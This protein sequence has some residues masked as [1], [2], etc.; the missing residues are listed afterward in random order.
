M[1]TKISFRKIRLLLPYLILAA[2]VSAGACKSLLP[3]SITPTVTRDSYSSTIQEDTGYP[4]QDEGL[5][6]APIVV[7]F[8]PQGGEELPVS[9]EIVLNFD[10][11]M[12]HQKTGEAWQLTGPDQIEIKGEFTWPDSRTMRFKPDTTLRTGTSYTGILRREAVS[13]RGIQ[14]E[15]PVLLNFTTTTPLEVSQVFP[16]DGSKDVAVDAVITAIFNRPVAPLVVE[17]DKEQLPDPMEINPPVP[18]RGEWVSTSVY[19]FQ[20]GKPLKGGMDYIVTVRAGL[21]DAAGETVLEEDV[22]WKFTT[23]KPSIQSFELSGGAVNPEPGLEGVLLDEYFTVNFNQPMDVGSSEESIKLL[24]EGGEPVSLITSWND[25]D[26]RVII[27]PTLDLQLGTSYSL[28]VDSTAKASDGGTLARGLNWNFR[29]I[30][31]PAVLTISPPEGQATSGFTPELWIKFASPMDFESVKEN[32]EVQPQ[33]KED[34]QW[35]YDPYDWSI[36]A[37]ILQPSTS[38]QVRALPGM[39]DIYGNSISTEKIVNFTT[40]QNWPMAGLQ[41]PWEPALLREGGPQEFYVTYR[42]VN[43]IGVK[44]YKIT[45]QEFI[46]LQTGTFNRSEFKPQEKDLVWEYELSNSGRI[47]ET[48]LESLTPV[49]TTGDALDPGFYFLVL[50]TPDISYPQQSSL[51]NRLMVVANADV[52]FKSSTDE[53]LL[54]VTDF[55]NG[56]PLENVSLTVYNRHFQP[57]GEGSTDE[58]GLLKLDLPGPEDPSDPRFVMTG[59]EDEFFAFTTSLWGSGVNLY[60]YGLWSSYYAPVNQVRVYAYTD[61]PIYR[62][63]QTVYYKGI[64]RRD[65]DLAYQLP[66]ANSAH[67]KVNNYKETVFEDD[68]PV[69]E[70]G[71]FSGEFTLDPDAVL[72]HY[73]IEVE[74]VDKKESVGGVGF[75]VAEYQRPEFQV[76][77]SVDAADL[78]NGEK[79]KAMVDADYY[80][81]GGVGNARVDW[82]LNASPFYFSPPEE[83]ANYSFEDTERDAGS[84]TDSQFQE[85]ETVAQGAGTTKPDGTFSVSLPADLSEGGFGRQLTFEATV[86]DISK[87]AVSGRA[88]VNAHRSMVYPG[89][90]PTSYVGTFGKENSF[91]LI[92]LDWDGKPVSGQNVA[93]EIVERRWYSVQ[94]Q[95]ASGRVE[96]KTNVEDIPIESLEATTD[97]L[98]QAKVSFVAPKGGVYRAT[99]SAEDTEGNDARSAAYLWVSGE[100][101]IPWRQTNDRSFDLVA[102]RSAYSPGDTAEILIASPFQGDST[103]LITVERGHILQQET[104]K[105]AS[106]SMVYKLPIAPEF[107]PNV[108]VSVLVVKGVDDTNPSP[109]FKMGVVELQVNTDQQKI[110]IEVS[111]EPQQA[112]PGDEVTYTIQA[113][114]E[115][116]EPLRAEFSLSLSD[117][118]TLSL[119]ESN[120]PPVLDFFYNERNLGVWTSAPLFLSLEDYNAEIQEMVAIGGGM[121]SGGGKGE[122]EL[123]VVSVRQDFPDTALWEAHIET[124][125]NGQAQVTVKLPDN[126]T[127]WRMDTRGVTLD[128]RVGQQNF[129]LISSK[130]LLVRPQTPRFLVEG[131]EAL[132]GTAVQNNTSQPLDV[133]VSLEYKG[134]SLADDSPVRIEIAAKS[135]ALVTWKAKADQGADRVDLVF[136]A[137]GGGFQDSSKP[138]QGTLEGHGIP[139]YRY[140]VRETA[141]TS[142]MLENGGTKIEAISLPAVNV[143]LQGSLHIEVSHS[144][145]AGLANGLNYL[146]DFPYGCIEQTISSFLPNVASTQAL[147]TAGI[148]NPQ[149][150]A[151]L[152]QQ[153]NQALQR[154]RNLQNPDGGWG[155]WP[156]D[157]QRSD[158]LTTAYVVLG[159]LE[160]RDRGYHVTED[161]LESAVNYL[162]TQVKFIRPVEKPEVLNR[163]AF[164]LDV[165][166]RAGKPNVSA[167]VRLY[168]QRQNAAIYARAFLLDAL[169]RIDPDDPRISTLLS[170]LNNQAISSAS[171][172]HWQESKPDPTNWNTDTRTTAIVLGIQSLIDSRNPLNA[173]AARWLMST[174][175]DGHWQGTQETAWTIMALTAWMEASGEAEPDYRYGVALNSEVLGGG[176]ADRQSLFET[177]ELIVQVTDMLKN[178]INRLAIARDDGSGN[179]YYTTFLNLYLPVE[180]AGALDQGIAISRSYI[181]FQHGDDL[182]QVGAVNEAMQGDLLLG[183]LTLVTPNDLHYIVVEDPLPAGLEAVDQTLQGSPQNLQPPA[184]YGL[185]EV[186]NQGWGWWYFD[187]T[188]LR[189]EKVVLSANY[190]PAGTYVYTYLVRAETAGVFNVIPPTAQEFYY[191]DVYGRGEG[192][193]FTV[194]P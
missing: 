19:A 71:T 87:N 155:W 92:L 102:D 36:R 26:T 80:S 86:S 108:F 143:D 119:V 88:V 184:D 57:I 44:L 7:D 95:D 135:Q 192:V 170:D 168:D 99:A 42:N 67:I 72:G 147:K 191:P 8:K 46:G 25:I 114:D 163:Q 58:D 62:P 94:E 20:P 138:P 70:F 175:T 158:S 128:T 73:S 151:D 140:Q 98:G 118:A 165:L 171:G 115:G 85:T 21:P 193:Q 28:V 123:G 183:R 51:D 122:D 48:V 129:D 1:K 182:S 12:D 100:G 136:S 45:P 139:V 154:L 117:L 18:G 152:A 6:I 96:W 27:T 173:S 35:W 29:T 180:E 15:E 83:Y 169:Y 172:T 132:I 161:Q 75:T 2:L 150:E 149:L 78:L 187:H 52:V 156:G 181:P 125:E 30:P 91:D 110:F 16:Q 13:S 124:D 167:T 53:G 137:E 176:T 188:E 77:V 23:T 111:A 186:F 177:S 40:P 160:A 69:S 133:R 166:A 130:P 37:F 32:I 56:Q 105:L 148:S 121:G 153:V 145:A 47:N 146:E 109:N 97:I 79:F 101:F 106:N 84:Y 89:I 66:E 190:L 116:G 90:R 55:E 178:E 50:D 14:L 82:T 134:V 93:V 131:D 22:S 189:D 10:Q 74:L 159:L 174:R 164:I 112:G 179:L 185:Q 9:G 38:Y 113:R 126:L 59:T 3:S 39:Q 63:D 76:K 64:L 120:T 144:L 103:A 61:R 65:D 54:W 104:V 162:R 24:P 60:D 141:G 81:G 194:N 33:P 4:V 127:T 5:P 142:G 49:K 107:A 31:P 68:L 17:E 11:D 41:M 43:S 34:I 157:D